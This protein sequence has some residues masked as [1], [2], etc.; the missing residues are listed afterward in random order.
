MIAWEKIKLQKCF[1][2][3]V[4]KKQKFL[5]GGFVKFFGSFGNHCIIWGIRLAVYG[6]LQFPSG[7]GASRNLFITY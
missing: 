1:L 5:V 4:Q 6:S 3:S 7:L 2:G